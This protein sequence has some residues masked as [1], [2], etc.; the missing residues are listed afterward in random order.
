M[1]KILI[2]FYRLKDKHSGLG[3]F[4]SQL[5]SFFLSNRMSKKM[6]LT[7]LVPEPFEADY[8]DRCST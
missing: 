8:K 7:F 3:Y 4:S 2:D 6:D 5:A 1:S